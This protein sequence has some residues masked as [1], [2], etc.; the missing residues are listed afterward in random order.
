MLWADPSLFAH[1]N[2]L[3]DVYSVIQ[4]HRINTVTKLPVILYSAEIDLKGRCLH[5]V[6]GG[7]FREN[8]NRKFDVTD[9]EYFHFR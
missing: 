4:M 7:L 3:N 6:L 2:T 9:L 5:V 1:A 8:M